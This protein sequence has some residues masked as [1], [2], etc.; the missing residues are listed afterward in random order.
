MS[1]FVLLQGGSKAERKEHEYSDASGVAYRSGLTVSDLSV[2]GAFKKTRPYRDR[3]PIYPFA[4]LAERHPALRRRESGFRLMH[5]TWEPVV[6]MLREKLKRKPRKS[7]STKAEH[8]GG[9]ARSSEEGCVM[10]LEQ[11]GYVIHVLTIGQ[12]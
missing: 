10:Q 12:P 7:E 1:D 4:L 3:S 8:R 9:I 2:C 6:P 11:R 5:G